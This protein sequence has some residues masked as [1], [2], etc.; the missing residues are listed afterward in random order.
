VHGFK[1]VWQAEI[2]TAEPLV[3]EP[4]ASEFELAIDKLKSHKTPGIEQIPAVLLKAGCYD[5]TFVGKFCVLSDIA[6]VV[7][8][9]VLRRKS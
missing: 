2:H 7:L 4:S 1:D 5:E 3:T 8:M 9:L 6:F